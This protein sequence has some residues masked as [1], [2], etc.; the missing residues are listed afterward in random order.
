METKSKNKTFITIILS[1]TMVLALFVI[2]LFAGCGPSKNNQT[3]PQDVNP[4][5]QGTVDD[6][7]TDSKTDDENKDD[8]NKDDEKQPEP[9]VKTLTC[10]FNANG[11]TFGEEETTKTVEQKVVGDNSFD[12][13]EEAEKIPTKE[14]STFVCW[15][16]TDTTTNDNN[17][18]SYKLAKS[19]VVTEDKNGAIFYAVWV[20]NN[21][22]CKITFDANGG[23]FAN[24][25]STYEVVKSAEKIG[26]NGYYSL[27]SEAKKLN[28]TKTDCKFMGWVNENGTAPSTA[29]LFVSGLRTEFK[30]T[31][32]WE[33]ATTCTFN[34]NGGIFE[35][36]NS[37]I[38]F[39]RATSEG[40]NFAEEAESL[41][42]TKEGCTFLG[43]IKG[44]PEPKVAESGAYKY[45]LAKY[46]KGANEEA[47][48]TFYALWSDYSECIITFNANGGAFENEQ[49]TYEV[50]KTVAD[51]AYYGYYLFSDTAIE[52]EK[53]ADKIAKTEQIQTPTREGYTFK[54]WAKTE[55]AKTI[56]QKEDGTYK[57]SALRN[58]FTFYAVWEEIEAN[59]ENAETVEA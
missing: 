14:G 33:E 8:E 26:K 54:G 35:G 13:S 43:W 4:S 5:D 36:G 44:E 57:V 53:D 55:N 18:F 7:N 41:N 37:Q 34:A 38:S 17:S 1:I 46:L 30:F 23:T 12:F 16:K 10:T 22:E 32:V 42:P 49:T 19:F 24:G 47:N 2:T 20:E 3:A 40:N 21:A 25:E 51:N 27:K 9:E 11:G 56:A 58:S 59:A 45:G 15:T 29:D 28:P 6:K 52:G 48:V 50:V 39:K 31:A